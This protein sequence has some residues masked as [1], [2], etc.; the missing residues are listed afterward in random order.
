V[1]S[2][3][4]A[5][6]SLPASGGVRPNTRGVVRQ[7]EGSEPGVVVEQ[8]SAGG[9]AEKQGIRP[10]DILVGWR[11]GVK[12]G[13]INSPF[14]LRTLEREQAPLGAV[15][16]D[17]RRNGQVVQ[18]TL[19]SGK[20]FASVR[21]NFKEPLL[22]Q[23]KAGLQ[24]ARSNDWNCGIAKLKT[25]AQSAE[26]FSPGWL[27]C[28][29][30]L[31][32][33]ELAFIAGRSDE[34]D[35]YYKQA[36][37]VADASAPG[38]APEVLRVWALSTERLGNVEEARRLYADLMERDRKSGKADLTTA[39][40]FNAVGSLEFDHED[41]DKAEDYVGRGYE[42]RKR[43]APGSIAVAR[44]LANLS[45]IASERGNVTKAEEY[46][47]KVLEIEEE[48][49]PDTLEVAAILVNLGAITT[50]AGS[51]DKADEYLSRALAIQKKLAPGGGG[52]AKS[53]N[54]LG[55]VARDRGDLDYA[56]YCFKQS[57]AIK[58]KV[59]DS[60][61]L[62]STLSSLAVVAMDRGDLSQA[63]RLLRRCLDI[64]EKAAP[65]SESSASYFTDLGCVV[66]R[67]GD[68]SKAETLLKQA[69]DLH[70][71]LHPESLESAQTLRELGDL[72]LDRGEI[73]QAEEYY[74]HAA[75][76]TAKIAP[77][78]LLNAELL[79][80]LASINA[81]RGHTAEAAQR[82][83][84]AL[85]AFESQTAQLGGSEI[86]RSEFRS[87]L[88]R[89]YKE[90]ISLL[91]AG[92]R[93]EL[94]FETVERARARTLLE[95]LAEGKF[96]LRRG[97]DPDLIEQERS[98][99]A[100]LSA[101]DRIR[102][103]IPKDKRGE[104]RMIRIEKD[105]KD[106]LGQYR[107]VEAQIRTRSPKYA[108]LTRP[109][110]LTASEAERLLDSDTI[111]LEYCLAQNKSY[112]FVVS[113]NSLKCYDLPSRATIY[114]AARRVHSSLTS[115]NDKV[116]GETN[117]QKRARKLKAQHEYQDGAQALSDMVLGPAAEQ[118]RASRRIV[119]ISDGALAYI[120]FGMLPL[121]AV[122]PVNGAR[123][124]GAN[125]E[126]LVD[127]HEIVNLPSMSTLAVLRNE[128]AGR[129]PAPQSIIVL[130]DPVFS[131]HDERL[132]AHTTGRAV[133]SGVSQAVP[134]PSYGLNRS[135]LESGRS[136]GDIFARLPFTRREADAICSIA[137]KGT[138]AKYLGFEA[139]KETVT[140][141]RMKDYRI[142]HLATHGLLNSIH[143]ELSGLVFSLIDRQG[144]TQDGF[145]RLTDIYNMD[146]NAD[147][148]VLS[149]CETALGKQIEEEG[150][151]GLTRAFMYAGAGRVVASLWNV[152]D[153]ATA[154]LM[155]KFYEGVLKEGQ[156]PSQALRAAQLW[157]RRQPAWQ[158][159]FYWAGF[160][161]QGDWR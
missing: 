26:G 108:A 16:I 127:H 55:L 116:I 19:G 130:A 141:P 88:A 9:E 98:I 144:R 87:S 150:M 23:Y 10:E 21:P 18:W 104:Q 140:N 65:S 52:M 63:E 125:P 139:N 94:A 89:Y 67:Q 50:D 49:T 24:C 45:I 143:P 70:Q 92:Q 103:S 4:F 69:L 109:Q 149:G 129:A 157:M 35:V 91:V 111:A 1:L 71:K 102:L 64:S 62:A 14:D 78:N 147:L 73:D 85:G 57:L 151:H 17:G 101:K 68:L 72:R 86:T 13:E 99:Q 36:F 51:L 11:L 148:V 120:P 60:L 54:N 8:A 126:L 84:Q 56:E 37:Q 29:V 158:S 33:A 105:I 136:A 3:G 30:L 82:Y 46:S 112:L 96:E 153:E 121:P 80:C 106:L 75:E 107:E 159:P 90:Y 76:I 118:I 117:V 66:R 53:L 95:T 48:L 135:A 132:G 43:L 160:V 134:K 31:H 42:I 131:T 152:D 161:V 154:A 142:V 83:E 110:R 128:L 32:T 113:R 155:A 156:T 137:G 22:S 138:A 40:D 123:P 145:L 74:S 146:L 27:E 93:P 44:S 61:D 7:V 25:C 133:V 15:T 34:A 39:A 79:G 97:V 47:R 12:K 114:A 100:D 38:V 2:I 119:V 77:G 81:E 124:V 5:L 115:S 6:I 41:L 20:W 122:G 28:W 58:E 59:S